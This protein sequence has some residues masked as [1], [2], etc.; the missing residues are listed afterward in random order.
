MLHMFLNLVVQPTTHINVRTI[1]HSISHGITLVMYSRV[2]LTIATNQRRVSLTE[3][4]ERHHYGTE[5][6][7]AAPS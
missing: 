2:R 3:D 7:N 1:Q 5:S 4:E 6:I